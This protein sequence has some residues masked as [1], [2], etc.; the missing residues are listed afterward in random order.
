MM[1]SYDT[2]HAGWID[3]RHFM[4]AGRAAHRKFA[5]GGHSPD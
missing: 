4:P 2:L 1:I 5:S 3:S